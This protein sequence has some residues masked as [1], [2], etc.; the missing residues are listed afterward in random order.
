MKILPEMF[1][2]LCTRKCWFFLR[3]LD[4]DLGIC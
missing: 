2:Y 4:W 1:R 3:H